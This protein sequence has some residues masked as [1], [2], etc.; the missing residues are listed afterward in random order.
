MTRDRK[1]WLLFGGFGAFFFGMGICIAIESGFWKH[2]GS[3]WAWWVFGGVFGLSSA[4]IGAFCMI[5]AGG[6]YERMRLNN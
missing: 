6:L 1:H 4:V 2:D 5:R 3:H